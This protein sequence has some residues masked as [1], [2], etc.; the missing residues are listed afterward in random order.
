MPIIPAYQE[1]EV[2]GFPVEGHPYLRNKIKTNGLS[3]AR[4]LA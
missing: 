1:T 3:V 4:E 2:G